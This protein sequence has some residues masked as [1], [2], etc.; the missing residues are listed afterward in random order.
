MAISAHRKQFLLILLLLGLYLLLAFSWQDISLYDESNYMAAGAALHAADFYTAYTIGPLYALWYRILMFFFHDAVV[1]YFASWA[2]LCIINALIPLTFRVQRAWLYALLAIASPLYSVQPYVSLFASTILLAGLSLLLARRRTIL[3]GAEIAL[4]V[5]FAMA[6]CRPEFAYAVFLAAA[7]VVLLAVAARDT[8]PAARWKALAMAVGLTAAMLTVTTH[9][10]TT[11]RSSGTAFAQ[12]VN[13]RASLRGRLG[14]EFPFT[15]AYANRLFGVDTAHNAANTVA[16][17]GEFAR[18][19]PRIFL[20]YVGYN[21]VDRRMIAFIVC[22]AVVAVLT[23]RR[24]GQPG[25]LPA[26]V[27]LLLVSFP[28][29]ASCL[30]ISP[31]HHYLMIVAP[32]FLL[33]A[34]Q[35]PPAHPFFAQSGV[36]IGLVAVC[37]LVLVGQAIVHARHR[38]ANP[39]KNLAAVDCLRSVDSHTTTVSPVS[40]DPLGLPD[41]Y[42]PRHHREVDISDLYPV[43]QFQNWVRTVRPGEVTLV[44]SAA[45]FYKTPMPQLQA[46]LAGQGYTPFVCP[47]RPSM[48]VYS[49]PQ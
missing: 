36:T 7:L 39:E 22:L 24:R 6:F 46:F 41:V 35:V 25:F 44:P 27:F 32:C 19:K 23:W 38:A 29:L 8:K 33:F 20:R 16:T 37:L 28:V 15:S 43:T 18:A 11:G 48:V 49:L 21:L 9:S 12:H 1:R 40:F 3:Y 2:L 14:D 17:I 31:E 47:N 34:L 26:G 4:V 30:L 45:Y 10:S 13:L 42:L 5:T